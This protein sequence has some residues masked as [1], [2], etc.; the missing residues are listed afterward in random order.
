MTV[1][2][3]VTMTVTVTVTDRNRDRSRDRD[4]VLEKQTFNRSGPRRI[5]VYLFV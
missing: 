4:H 1:I 3:T 2:V 5:H